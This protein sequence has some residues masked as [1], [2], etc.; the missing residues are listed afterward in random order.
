MGVHDEMMYE[1]YKAECKASQD[2]EIA[3]LRAEVG[4]L[5]GIEAAA[6]RMDAALRGMQDEAEAE[7]SDPKVSVERY[8][9]VLAE[10]HAAWSAMRAALDAAEGGE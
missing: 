5:R 6:T 8:G 1:Q 7:P 3:R 9:K 10:Y 2:A 4:R